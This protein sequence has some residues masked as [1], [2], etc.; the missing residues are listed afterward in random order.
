MEQWLEPRLAGA[1]ASLRARVLQAV[2]AQGAGVA[3][4]RSVAESLLAEAK[5][6]PPTRDT[7]LTLLAADALI[8]MVAEAD[9]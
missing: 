6:A 9:S 2:R 1:P 4:L 3:Q 5:T 7:A 8:T